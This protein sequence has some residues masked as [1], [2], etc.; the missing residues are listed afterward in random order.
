VVKD[1]I[2][3]SPLVYSE[4]LN[5]ISPLWEGVVV[6]DYEAVMPLPVQER[7]GYKLIQMPG[8]VQNFGLFSPV[9]ELL[10][11]DFDMFL[12]KEFNKFRFISYS[13]VFENSYFEESNKIKKRTTYFIDLEKSYED[14]YNNYTKSHR[15]NL[16]RFS[17]NDLTIFESNDPSH[18]FKIRQ[19]MGNEISQMRMPWDDE[20]RWEK[21]IDFATTKNTGKIVYAKHKDSVVSGGF[22]LIGSKRDVLLLLGSSSTGKENKAS[23]G[24]IDYYLKTRCE[25]KKILDFCGSDIAGIASFFEGFGANKTNYIQ[26]KR[27]RLPYLI[28]GIKEHNILDKVKKRIRL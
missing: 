5:I 24:V 8:D 20:K 28:K 13:F 27:N 14:I 6:G 1:S 9:K 11:I 4:V 18:L 15:K 19:S 22:Y 10:D 23:F 25:Q 12:A 2:N 21:L 3:E 16:R 26:Y 7:L 17:R